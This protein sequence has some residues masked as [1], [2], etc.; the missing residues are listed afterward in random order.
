MEFQHDG[1]LIERNA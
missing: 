1:K